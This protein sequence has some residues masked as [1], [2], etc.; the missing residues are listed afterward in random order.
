MGV[1]LATLPSPVS[2]FTDLEVGAHVGA[3]PAEGW[4][5]CSPAPPLGLLV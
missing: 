5:G 4:A 3:A 2:G 1:E